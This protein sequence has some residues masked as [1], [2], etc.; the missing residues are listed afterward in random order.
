MPILVAPDKF[1][2][3][4]SAAEVAAAIADGLAAGGIGDIERLPVADGGEGT[5][6]AVLV[7]RS[8]RIV[9]RTVADPLGRPVEARFAVLEEGR[10]AVV[11][12]AQACGL[13]RLAPDERDPESATSRG[14]GEL[15]GAAITEGVEQVVAAVGG[16]ASTD[17]GRGAL[18]ALG[19]RF[20][21]DRADLRG[22]T[23]TLGEVELIVACDVDNP[24]CG[25]SGAAP[26]FAPQK[27]AGEAAVE[28]LSARLERWSKLADQATGRDPADVARA[29]AGGGIAGGLWAF[30]G[31][32][33]RDGAGFVLDTVGF[34]AKLKAAAAV[35]TGE[36]RL[37]GQTLRGKVVARVAERSLA[38]RVQ[39]VAIVGRSTLTAAEASRL[40]IE[41]IEAAGDRFATRAD[42][43]AAARSLA[44]R[45]APPAAT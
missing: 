45:P 40:G 37:D 3:T 9:R 1:K 25:P 24:M 14:A 10:I 36:G 17:G 12:I 23:R 27:G 11:E 35:V 19:A 16:S 26:T 7:A 5:I 42:V 8:G 28:R 32:S 18:E 33:L 34:G 20:E 2:G 30:A 39:C 21:G 4:I 43:E 15:I 22:L 44:L 41:V 13:W 38:A 31:A 6:E 29:G